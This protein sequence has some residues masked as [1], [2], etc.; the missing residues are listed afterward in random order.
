MLSAFPAWRRCGSPLSATINADA[1]AVTAM[2]ERMREASASR[3]H[4]LRPRAFAW[5]AA[6]S[7]CV[8]HSSMAVRFVAYGEEVGAKTLCIFKDKS[9]PM[10]WGERVEN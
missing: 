6:W 3:I 9:A 5:C 1:K 8:W 7:A 4:Y 2:N 10:E